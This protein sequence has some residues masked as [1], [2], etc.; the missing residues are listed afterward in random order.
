MVYHCEFA[1]DIEM[2]KQL[3]SNVYETVTIRNEKQFLGDFRKI[4]NELHV[5]KLFMLL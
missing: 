4:L 1:L 3:K 2:M 5:D